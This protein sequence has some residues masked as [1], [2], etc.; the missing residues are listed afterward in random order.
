MMLG[1]WALLEEQCCGVGFRCLVTFSIL[2]CQLSV[3]D[4]HVM[5]T[6]HQRQRIES[7]DSESHLCQST[8]F[9]CLTY[10]SEGHFYSP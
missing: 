8:S 5:Q 3:G 9:V 2:T 4:T 7:A 1:I 10:L 6:H